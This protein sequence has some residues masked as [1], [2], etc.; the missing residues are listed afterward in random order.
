MHNICNHRARVA[1]RFV[2]L[3]EYNTV[4]AKLYFSLHETRLFANPGWVVKREQAVHCTWLNPIILC[5]TCWLVP[6]K[7]TRTIQ[8]SVHLANH[9]QSSRNHFE[10]HPYG[11]VQKGNS[12]LLRRLLDSSVCIFITVITVFFRWRKGGTLGHG[13]RNSCAIRSGTWWR[14]RHGCQGNHGKLKVLSAGCLILISCTYRLVPGQPSDQRFSHRG[15][16]GLGHP[17]Q[18]SQASD[19]LRPG[20]YGHHGRKCDC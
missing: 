7:I 6:R 16:K 9:V 2:P 3:R 5:L 4:V 15:G 11:V 12:S 20:P 17:G 10:F 13:K 18:F 1:W 14:C 19:E 8:I